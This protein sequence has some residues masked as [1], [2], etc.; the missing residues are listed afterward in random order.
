MLLSFKTFETEI[1]GTEVQLLL[2]RAEHSLCP[3]SSLFRVYVRLLFARQPRSYSRC[4]RSRCRV[5]STAI[6]VI[7]RLSSRWLNFPLTHSLFIGECKLSN[8]TF[9]TLALLGAFLGVQI[10]RLASVSIA[11]VQASISQ[12]GP[13]L[14]FGATPLVPCPFVFQP[15]LDSAR[16]VPEKTLIENETKIVAWRKLALA[17]DRTRASR[18]A[19]E[20][21]TAEPPVLLR[22]SMPIS[23]RKTLVLK[24]LIRRITYKKRPT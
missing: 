12:S 18:V 24:R 21:S 5:L 10:A 15:N 22:L 20:N 9:F 11:S 23:Y 17:G 16:C 2:S 13:R 14:R 1:F 19:G 3:A 7:Y 8:T 4:H 6:I